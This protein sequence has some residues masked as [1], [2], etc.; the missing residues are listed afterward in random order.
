MSRPLMALMLAALLWGGAVTGTKYALGGFGPVTLLAVELTAAAAVLWAVTLVR[1]YRPPRRWWVPV[2]LGLLEPAVAYLAETAG[3]SMT[4]AVSGAVITG[5]ESALVVTLA[6]LLLRER[7]TPAAAGA[8]TVAVAGLL[9]LA[10]AGGGDGIG[11]RTSVTG[12]LL[13][14]AGVLSAA[15]YTIAARR[16]SDGS[17]VLSLTAWQFTVAAAVALPAAVTRLASGAEAGLPAGVPARYWVAAVLVGVAG[18]GLSF[19][20][21]NRAIGETEAG[22]AAIVLN[23]IPVFGFL[24]AVVFLG[25]HVSPG[26]AGGAA[27]VGASVLYFTLAERRAAAPEPGGSA[28]ERVGVGPGPQATVQRGDHLVVVGGELEVEDVDVLPHPGRGDRLGEHDV[29]ALDVPAQHDLGRGL[30]G[31]LGDRHDLR[32]AEKVAAAGQG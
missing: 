31:P 24:S 25:E 6:G 11:G 19:L 17:D 32:V 13:M 30:A 9:V 16:F 1:G 8:V 2:L 3:L 27:L 7:V 5:L 29:A 28:G 15:L 12:D 26:E 4:S 22:W 20:L 21:F 10:R 23:L 18:Y 14:A